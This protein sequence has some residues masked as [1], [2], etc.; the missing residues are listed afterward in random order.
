VSQALRE[1]GSA[2]ISRTGSRKDVARLR[3]MAAGLQYWEGSVAIFPEGTRSRDGK[4]Q[5][6][7]PAAVRIV[8]DVAKL[9]ILPVAIDGTYDVSDLVGFTKNMTGAQGTLTIGQPIAPEAW[10]GNLDQV[11]QDVREWIVDTVE[12]GRA[13]A[14]APV[15]ADFADAAPVVPATRAAAFSQGRTQLPSRNS[16]GY[17]LPR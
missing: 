9:P 17:H 15:R 2:L 5:P 6:F 7:K 14:K 12:R 10:Q 1:W 8:A 16:T 4:V 3:E 11:V 13:S